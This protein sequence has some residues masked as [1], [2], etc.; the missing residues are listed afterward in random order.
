[1][2]VMF[3]S[4][5]CLQY[6]ES[7]PSK[8]FF[9]SNLWKSSWNR[10]VCRQCWIIVMYPLPGRQWMLWLFHFTSPV[11]C[12]NLFWFFSIS[13]WSMSSR[14]LN[15][16]LMLLGLSWLLCMFVQLLLVKSFP[17]PILP[18][19]NSFL[20]KADDNFAIFVVHQIA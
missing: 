18:H 2:P 4:Y 20:L 17:L 9:W 19:L 6:H 5:L 10:P 1:M 16:K 13:L 3:C 7:M 15:H 11:S 14:Y 8:C 12:W